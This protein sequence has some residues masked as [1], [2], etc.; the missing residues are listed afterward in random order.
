MQYVKIS[1]SPHL[2]F[3][4]GFLNKMSAKYGHGQVNS[5][6]SRPEEKYVAVDILILRNFKGSMQLA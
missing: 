5:S 1:P 4:I 2:F 3:K 6:L